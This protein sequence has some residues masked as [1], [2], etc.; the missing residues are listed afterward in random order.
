MGLRETAERAYNDACEHRDLALQ[1]LEAL[2]GDETQEERQAALDLFDTAQA[3]VEKRKKESDEIVARMEA[4]AATPIIVQ[5]ETTTTSSAGEVR[6][7]VP[8]GSLKV[9]HTYRPDNGSSFFRDL[10]FSGRGDPGASE[11]LHR[12][13]QETRDLT[14]TATDG[15]GFVPPLYLGELYAKFPRAG[16]PLANAVGS[17]PLPAKG[18]SITLPRITT[19]PATAFQT[20]EN[21]AMNETEMVEATVTI[22]VCTLG[23]IE[24]VSIQLLERSDPPIDDV[25]FLSL[26]ESYDQQLD[27]A[28]INGSGSGATHAG[29]VN[30][31]GINTTTYTDASPTAAETVPPIYEAISEVATTRY[32]NAD[33]IIMHPRRAAWLAGTLSANQS[34]FQLGSLTNAVGQQDQGFV[35]NF[36]GLRVVLD[37]NVTITNGA[38]TNE[39]QI[40][41]V[42]SPDLILW[43]G[44][45]RAEVFRETLSAEG[46]VRLRLYAFSAWASERYP[47]AISVVSG[48]GLVTPSFT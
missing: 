33:M 22:P 43:E 32:R 37:P 11:R 10:Y 25:I 18:M 14:T 45:L 34:L 15:G 13:G 12:H 29:L 36:A 21:T 35:G 16:R 3:D 26:R 46:T 24:D 4:R 42:H 7:A 6:F 20:T 23:G 27:N 5:T 48:T 47:S 8:K 1:A 38:S 30:V 17:R 40:I 2:T 9:E 28:L 31:S 39:D 44:D 41:V 19:A